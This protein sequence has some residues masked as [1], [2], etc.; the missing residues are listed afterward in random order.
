MNTLLIALAIYLPLFAATWAS[1]E[2]GPHS[3]PDWGGRWLWPVSMTTSFK[4]AADLVLIEQA[5]AEIE[6]EEI[7]RMIAERRR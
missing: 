6:H 5:Y 2:W 4:L 7:L 3:L 1:L